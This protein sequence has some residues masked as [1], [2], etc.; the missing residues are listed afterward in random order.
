M[1]IGYFMGAYIILHLLKNC[2]RATAVTKSI[3]LFP[4]IERMAIMIS[5][6]SRYVTPM[7]TYFKWFTI[8]AVTASPCLP[9]F[10]KN[11]LV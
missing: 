3:L 10:V 8:A 4:T 11:G 1:L 7:V 5:P 6:S 9:E 2:S